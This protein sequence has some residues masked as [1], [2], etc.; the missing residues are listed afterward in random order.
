MPWDYKR[1]GYQG[2]V[3]IYWFS[4]P[5]YMIQQCVDYA[6]VLI[7]K[8]P[9][10]Q[11]YIWGCWNTSLNTCIRSYSYIHRYVYMH[12]ACWLQLR[13]LCLSN[14]IP[15]SRNSHNFTYYAH[16]ILSA[17]VAWWLHVL[18]VI[19]LINNHI[20]KYSISL[21]KWLPTLKSCL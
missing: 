13:L 20:N 6:G 10:L 14:I 15:L 7:F 19:M 8:Y 21:I 5:I 9:D 4:R 3:D 2:V 18:K 11:V 12:I 1:P 17:G 16:H